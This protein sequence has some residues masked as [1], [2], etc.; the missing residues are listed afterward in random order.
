MKIKN[1]MWSRD[2]ISDRVVHYLIV[3]QILEHTGQ[4]GQF[5]VNTHRKMVMLD[6]CHRAFVG[7]VKN[8]DC[9]QKGIESPILRVFK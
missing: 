8:F 1:M 6:M 3:V 5:V 7:I 4:S 2:M 9:L